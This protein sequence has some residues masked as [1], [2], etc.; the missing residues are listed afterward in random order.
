MTAAGRWTAAYQNAQVVPAWQPSDYYVAHLALLADDPGPTEVTP[1]SLVSGDLCQ[2]SELWRLLLTTQPSL[3]GYANNFHGYNYTVAT[4]ARSSH[5]LIPCYA[6]NFDDEYAATFNGYLVRTAYLAPNAPLALLERLAGQV[7]PPIV[8]AA[9]TECV[10]RAQALDLPCW[11]LQEM[12]PPTLNAE[13]GLR[14]WTPTRTLTT[15]ELEALQNGTLHAG[16][17]P[18]IFVTTYPAEYEF[19]ESHLNAFP[20]SRLRLLLVRSQNL[21]VLWNQWFSG[22]MA[23]TLCDVTRA[24]AK[25]P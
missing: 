24:G 7:V 17:E 12:T 10:R 20:T 16:I 11:L 5:F 21:F 18:N 4:M 9:T 1:F 3:H 15:K 25:V 13:I 22:F 2:L 8:L 6:R 23:A 19:G 14:L